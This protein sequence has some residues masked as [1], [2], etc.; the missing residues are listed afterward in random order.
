M[1]TL[2]F[3]LEVLFQLCK[4]Y[5]LLILG[6][7]SIGTPLFFIGIKFTSFAS[8][9]IPETKR[10]GIAGTYNVSNLPSE[11]S[12]YISS[13][14]TELSLNGRATESAITSRWTMKNEGKEYLF[15]LKPNLRWQDGTPFSS[16]QIQYQISGVSVSP[17]EG[18][19]AF[20]LD[21]PFS[22]FPTLLV[23]PI[24]KKGKVGLGPY[25]IQNLNITS[26]YLHSLLLVSISNQKSKILF[27][28]Y[29][30][31]TDLL[32]AFKLGE[33]DEAW[34]ISNSSVV[35][36]KK[37]NVELFENGIINKY[38]ALFFNTKKEQFSSKRVRQILAYALEKP[39]KKDRAFGPIS[40]NCWA[41]SE[42]VKTY[43]F[44]PAH[45]KSLLEKEKIDK[46]TLN[47]IKIYTLPELLTWAEKIKKDWQ[48]VLGIS[49][50]IYV[51][52]LIPD[53]NDYEVFLGY[54]ITPPDPDQY[55]FWHSTQAGNLTGLNNPKIDQLLEKGRKT[56]DETERKKIYQ[57]FQLALSEEV[58]AIFLFYP[59]SFNVIRK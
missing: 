49:S 39:P 38:V 52:N 3:W 22:P 56:L 4:K 31:E 11:I 45:A 34:N 44:D 42:R 46:N 1:R 19:L 16:D 27:R 5:G 54:G 21:S 51:T 6:G 2:R 30:N 28:F 40:P 41:Y 13:G 59:Q 7:I 25:K 29:S 36:D 17:F 8:R 14:L 53:F 18:G 32:T 26:G 37:G 50:E 9:L 10:I 43:P 48:E 12:H 15:F 55:F 35:S 57:E 24:L 33:I 23:K 58:P 47:P 20:I